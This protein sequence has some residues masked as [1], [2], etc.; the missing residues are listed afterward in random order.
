M[1][2]ILNTNV[3][4]LLF[5]LSVSAG[6]YSL[7]QNVN[8][9]YCYN[10]KVLPL[11]NASGQH[12]E[13]IFHQTWDPTHSYRLNST[14]PEVLFRA[15]ERLCNDGYELWP[16]KETVLRL[17][18]WVFPAVVLVA[19]FHFPPL[20]ISNTLA[21]IAH[22]IGDPIDSMW[23]MLTRQEVSRRIYRCV[24]A[25]GM[26][27]SSFIAPVLSVYEEIGWQNALSDWTHAWGERRKTRQCNASAVETQPDGAHDANAS[28]P[29]CAKHPRSFRSSIQS[30]RNLTRKATA[31]RA[32]PKNTS[33][34]GQIL[35]EEEKYLILEA[36]H[37]IT[38]NRSD[39]ELATWFAIIGLLGAI[40]GALFRT[41][42]SGQNGNNQTP[43]TIAIATMLSILIPLVKV[44]GNIGSFTSISTVLDIVQDLR[45]KLAY[46]RR[47]NNLPIEP[48]LFPMFKFS[49]NMSW[50]DGSPNTTENRADNTTRDF[51]NIEN[52]GRLAPW[53]GMNSC[54][55]PSK[56]PEIADPNHGRSHLYLGFLSVSVVVLGSYGPA[57]CLS[58]FTPTDGFGCRSLAWTLVMS[59]WAISAII[60]FT[61]KYFI[62]QAKTLWQSTI[63]KDFIIT[64]SII[65]IIAVAQVGVFNSCWCNSSAL[66]L[67]S[68][69]YYAFG[70]F[71]D[72][73]W[74]SGVKLW[75]A[76]PLFS[77]LIAMGFIY[78]VRDNGD[79]GSNLLSRSHSERQINLLS[80]A[81]RRRRWE[82]PAANPPATTDHISPQS[83]V[84]KEA[85]AGPDKR[86]R[87]Y[88]ESQFL[89]HRPTSP[90]PPSPRPT[91]SQH[92]RYEPQST[93]GSSKSRRRARQG[94]YG[95]EQMRL[96]E[97]QARR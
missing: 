25:V 55:R 59:L 64:L 39:S 51:E 63:A 49:E 85:V 70:P 10:E 17:I 37:Q 8:F 58:Y 29:P 26:E 76:C 32:L 42:S 75:I 21:V 36:C 61:L 53:C 19:H 73:E 34:E 1:F 38:S 40:I 66:S 84:K 54:W 46:H 86:E 9:S 43:H 35:D 67:H 24:S 18:L 77:I 82:E 78:L 14:R 72:S 7:R 13:G 81:G 44:S 90:L 27:D 2:T 96:T 12:D 80:L 57:L 41:L 47:D 16:A 93:D 94:G 92:H 91:D 52:W 65:I 30:I 22:L 50:K 79:K 31:V 11:W 33:G 74:N 69:A 28:E 15:C 5:T 88:A 3:A 87:I 45:R 62:I 97:T 60:D 95:Y 4:L 20:S 89:P 23:S 6:A 56:K 83:P 48:E 71:T 68:D